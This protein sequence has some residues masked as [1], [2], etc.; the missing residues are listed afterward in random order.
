MSVLSL[1]LPYYKN[2]RMLA[3]QFRIWA[4]YPPDLKD[5][6]EIVLVDDG[7]PAELAAM[8]VP[9]PENL[10]PLRIYRVLVDIPWH[11]HGAR[12]LAAHEA[13]GPWLFLTDMDHVLPADSLRALLARI[14]TG[15]DA[16]Y[17]FQRLDAPDLR[18]TI[19]ER[20][21]L[22]P[23]CNTF[24]LTKARYWRVGGYDED[25]VG[26]GTD[27]YFRRRLFVKQPATHLATVPIIRYPREVIADASGSQPG[28]DPKAF[29]NAGRRRA[30][31]ARRL[32]AKARTG[33]G[34]SVL[35]FPW[36]RVR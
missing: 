3:E 29:R 11:Q 27:G 26:Y 32:A 15:K 22:K 14:A 1:C 23:H 19:N 30:E 28:M 31:T 9:P 34:P 16:I 25:C 5:Q 36:E 7:S 18:P 8:T 17:T 4:A 20:G 24:A 13:L 2:P 21:N 33:K 35:A 6:I 10:P 12:N